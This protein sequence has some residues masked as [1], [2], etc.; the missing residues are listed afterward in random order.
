MSEFTAPKPLS[1][2]R[3]V[4]LS[5]AG[6]AAGWLPGVAGG[7]AKAAEGVA[8]TRLPGE[9]GVVMRKALKAGMIGAG[10]TVEEKLTIA[11]EAGFAGVE[12][13]GPLGDDLL[14]E[15]KAASEATGMAIPG[16]VCG[17]VGR[18][19]GSADDAERRQGIGEYTTAL[20]QAAELGGTSVL[21][22]PG[23]V[24]PQNRYDVVFDTLIKSTEELLPVAEQTGVGIALENVWNNLF[25]SPLDAVRFCEHFDHEK[26][27]WYFDIGNIVRYGWPE[28]WIRILGKRV[29]KLDIKGYSRELENENGPWAGFR[30]S[31]PESTI[32]WNRVVA[33]LNEVGY[34]GE[35]VS[36]EV[37]GGD[38]ERLKVI[39]AEMDE[40]LQLV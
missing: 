1:R 17:A 15:V 32:D 29:L 30:V 34:A 16:L 35:W 11:R 21:M 28:Q 5:A 19:L 24:N 3:F 4:G 10:D 12:F 39:S 33:A 31:L 23:A 27:G 2:R 8:L 22:Y 20:H 7:S 13:E 25:L 36:A 6:V 14:A 38:L 18:K 9:P 37:G 26:V 40:V